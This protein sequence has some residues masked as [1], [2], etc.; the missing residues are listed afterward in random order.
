[1]KV[2]FG[3]NVDGKFAETSVL[4]ALGHV[5]MTSR[6]TWQTPRSRTRSTNLKNSSSRVTVTHGPVQSHRQR[7]RTPSRSARAIFIE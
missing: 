5:R 4:D 6:L 7:N 3:G 2:E 1:M